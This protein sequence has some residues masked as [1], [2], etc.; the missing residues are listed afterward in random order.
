MFVVTHCKY[1]G[2]QYTTLDTNVTSSSIKINQCSQCGMTLNRKNQDKSKKYFDQKYMSTRWDILML[3]CE[4]L[5]LP[6]LNPE[7]FKQAFS[8]WLSWKDDHILVRASS[9]YKMDAMPY[10]KALN[11]PCRSIGLNRK[12]KITPLRVHCL[13]S[14]S[15]RPD[16]LYVTS[17][18]TDAIRIRYYVTEMDGVPPAVMFISPRMFSEDFVNIDKFVRPKKVIFISTLPYLKRWRKVNNRCDLLFTERIGIPTY[19][20][21][22]IMEDE[23]VT[24]NYSLIDPDTKQL[25]M[26]AEQLKCALGTLNAQYEPRYT[27]FKTNAMSKLLAPSQF[28]GRVQRLLRPGEARKKYPNRKDPVECP[29]DSSGD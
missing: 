10:Y 3:F 24:P 16:V 7:I 6:S 5:M 26:G 14:D 21:T 15:Y 22:R 1:C 28:E 12:T 2:G 23:L 11:V 8:G 17:K 19:L 27:G 18:F 20:A 9:S 25:Y 13:M 29:E 4:K